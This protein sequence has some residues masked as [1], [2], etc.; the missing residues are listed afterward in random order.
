M[1]QK[2]KILWWIVGDKEKEI[3]EAVIC[4]LE[5]QEQYSQI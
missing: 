2:T 1:L 5:L 3:T 4:S